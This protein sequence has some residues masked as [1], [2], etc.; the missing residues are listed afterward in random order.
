MSA[1]RF[2]Y[3]EKKRLLEIQSDGNVTLSLV[4]FNSKKKFIFEAV[5]NDTDR[6]NFFFQFTKYFDSMKESYSLELYGE[7][8]LSSA[9]PICSLLF[10]RFL[11]MKHVDTIHPSHS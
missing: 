10:V 3:E 5:N 4:C 7:H 2:L 8:F 9:Q 6:L 11:S 1:F